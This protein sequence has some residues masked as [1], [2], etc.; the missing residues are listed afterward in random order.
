MLH[1]GHRSD[2]HLVSII[3]SLY[4]GMVGGQ[5]LPRS[6]NIWNS[7]EFVFLV[8]HQ[9]GRGCDGG[10]VDSAPIRFWNV[11]LDLSCADVVVS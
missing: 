5:A 4:L 3:F 1:H 10:G 8:W 9:D 11:L 7:S 6:A 2:A